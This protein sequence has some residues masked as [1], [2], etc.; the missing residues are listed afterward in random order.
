[1]L[2][3]KESTAK[4]IKCHMIIRS[5]IIIAK[6]MIMDYTKYPGYIEKG[7]VSKIH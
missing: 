5:F 2:F 7:R 4:I 3:G 1:M 6:S